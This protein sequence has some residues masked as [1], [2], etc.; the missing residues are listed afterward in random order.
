MS[1]EEK[2]A[3]EVLE[4]FTKIDFN[5]PNGWTGYYDTELKELSQKINIALNLIRKQQEE[6]E[7]ELLE[8]K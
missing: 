3:I 1:E 6:I 8:G 2:K 5:N 7:E 4:S